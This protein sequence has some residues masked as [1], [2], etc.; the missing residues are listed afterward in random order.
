MVK[1]T[2]MPTFTYTRPSRTGTGTRSRTVTYTDKNKTVPVRVTAH[3]VIDLRKWCTKKRPSYWP[4]HLNWPKDIAKSLIY[5]VPRDVNT[6]EKTNVKTSNAVQPLRIKGCFTGCQGLNCPNPKRK[7]IKRTD[8]PCTCMITSHASLNNP[9]WF[10]NNVRLEKT[11]S[12]GIGT[13]ALSTFAV[14]TVV[15][16]YVGE[17][18][19][20]EGSMG[21]FSPYMFEMRNNRENL[22]NMD[23]L[24]DYWHGIGVEKCCCGEE[25][26]IG[27]K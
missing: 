13:I 11:A 15:G 19:P 23:A 14:G 4:S 22:G 6:T 8:P 5:T 9:T 26:C 10:E 1:L 17:I 18:V 12:R 16:E 20:A 2:S 25:S 3:N 7:G 27:K 24:K 21:Y